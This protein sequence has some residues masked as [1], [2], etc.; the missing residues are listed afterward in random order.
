VEVGLEEAAVTW[1][2]DDEIFGVG[3]QFVDDGG[4]SHCGRLIA[5]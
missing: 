2:G 3:S 4:V 1:L 5:A